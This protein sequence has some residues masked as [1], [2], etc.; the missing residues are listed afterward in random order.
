MN[1]GMK[2]ILERMK[3][4]PEEF[5]PDYSNPRTQG[6]NKWEVL[7]DKY[8]KNLNPEDIH[9]FAEAFDAMR[10]E[11]FTAQVMKELMG[12]EE[13]EGSLGKQWFT[14]NR[15]NVTLSA[16]QTL[17]QFTT[18]PYSTSTGT[19]TL[20]GAEHMKAH[21]KAL[22]QE[23]ADVFEKPKEHKTLFGKLWNYL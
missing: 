16:G 9:A 1:D 15:G 19:I 5:Q 21:L 11:Q 12:S 7:I 3:T 14:S 18:T 2:I 20:E 10:Q 6:K 22:Q 17:G 23:Y 4:H 8:E 13:D